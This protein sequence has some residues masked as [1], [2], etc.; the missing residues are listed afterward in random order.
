MN[1][2]NFNKAI[3]DAIKKM[4]E[5]SKKANKDTVEIVVGDNIFLLYEDDDIQMKMCL[6]IFHNEIIQLYFDIDEE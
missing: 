2:K 6:E 4:A 5:Y 3:N 1:V